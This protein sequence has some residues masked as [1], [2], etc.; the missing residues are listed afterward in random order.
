MSIK[1]QSILNIAGCLVV[2][3]I[4]TIINF[5]LSPY[6]VKNLGVE[7]NGYITLAN[8]FVSYFSLITTALNSMAG[9]FMLVELKRG[10][11]DQANGYYTSVL[12]GDWLL[13]VALL[14]PAI[15]LIINLDKVIQIG[16]IETRDV[17]LLFGLLFFNFFF[18]LCIPKW[19]NATYS[20]NRLYLRSIKT[21]ISA[22]A[23]ALAIY[24][25]YRFFKPYAFYVAMAGIVMTLLNTMIEYVYKI[26]LLPEVKFNWKYFDEE[27]IK[28]LLSSGIWNTITQCGNL[29]LEGLDVLIANIFINPVASGVLS[30]AKVVPNMLNQITG[31]IATTFGPPITYLYAE[32]KMKELKTEVN[33]NIK[34]VAILAN[35]PIGVTFV[36]GKDFFKLWVPSQDPNK[37]SVLAS[38]TLMGILISGCG[39]CINNVFIAVNKLKLNSI[40]TIVTGIVNIIAVYILLSKTNLDVYVIAGT[41]SCIAYIRFLGFSAPY[42][43]VCIGQKWYSFYFALFKAVSNILIPIACGIVSVCLIEIN[44][45]LTFLFAVTLTCALTVILDIGIYLNKE[46]RHI[47]VKKFFGGQ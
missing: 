36:L 5:F 24:L 4:N 30:V 9:R 38:L 29:L 26:N 18:S 42:A 6:I 12:I 31:N 19:S 35:I 41:S 8:N 33:R 40:I 17:K 39:C 20:T 21:V 25:A 43:A 15:L 7:A 2:V 32:G 34:L 28:V 13:S 27:K 46:E 3:C 16:G 47:V 11:L 14:V 37:L 23:R 10:N 1:Q 45:W 22:I 44:S